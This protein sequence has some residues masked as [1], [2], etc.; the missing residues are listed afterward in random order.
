MNAPQIMVLALSDQR[1]ASFGSIV[2]AAAWKAQAP[3]A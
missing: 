1:R 2:E 3:E